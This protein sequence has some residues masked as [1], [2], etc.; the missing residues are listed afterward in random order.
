MPSSLPEPNS[1]RTMA[2]ADQHQAV[3]QAVADAVQKLSQGRVLHGI[4]L[5]AAHHDAVGD[6]QADEHRQLAC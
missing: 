3:A 4:G 6:D 2:T 5:G 1:S